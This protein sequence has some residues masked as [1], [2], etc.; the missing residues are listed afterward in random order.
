MRAV[1]S[2]PKLTRRR[3]LLGAACALAARRSFAGEP[4]ALAF[5]QLYESYG[6]RGLVFSAVLR[7]LAGHDVVMR[8]YMA[9]P[10]KPR[11]TSSSSPA[12]RSRSARSASRT[13]NGRPTSSS[14]I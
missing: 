6:V 8:G 13:P 11:A 12:N 3:A 10:L 2:V 9:P 14:S 7:N 5:E 1:A 4:A